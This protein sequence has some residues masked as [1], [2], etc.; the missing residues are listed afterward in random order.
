MFTILYCIPYVFLAMWIEFLNCPTGLVSIELPLIVIPL[1][2]LAFMA[3]KS[4]RKREILVGNLINFTVS[5]SFTLFLYSFGHVLNRCGNLWSVYFEPL[6]AVT[7]FLLLEI[8]LFVLQW[9]SYGIGISK[10]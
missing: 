9:I 10:K 5:G 8:L 4:Q 7:L 1:C 3:G 2:V 6:N